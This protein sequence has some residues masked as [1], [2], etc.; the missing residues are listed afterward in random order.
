[1]SKSCFSLFIV[2]LLFLLVLFINPIYGVVLDEFYSPVSSD[3]YF[4][5]ENLNM[6]FNS[7]SMFRIN[8]DFRADTGIFVFDGVFL[9]SKKS[10]KKSSITSTIPNAYEYGLVSLNTN[11][12][13]YRL[14][15][16]AELTMVILD[17]DGIDPESKG[18]AK[19]WRPKEDP[20][21]NLWPGIVCTFNV[22]PDSSY[23][24]DEDAGFNF[25]SYGLLKTGKKFPDDW[26]LAMQRIE[27][28]FS[29]QEFED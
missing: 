18:V 1:M 12:S 22:S 6:F 26:H 29:S 8:E 5:D 4:F 27:M 11:K 25:E 15:E 3:V 13:I 10:I 14:G 28:D 7:F 23:G 2:F 16:I 17:K 24:Y 19:L 21:Q 9:D 20:V